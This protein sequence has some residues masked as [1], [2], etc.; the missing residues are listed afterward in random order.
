MHL[1]WVPEQTVQIFLSQR[2]FLHRH[3]HVCLRN[4]DRCMLQVRFFLNAS[5][6]DDEPIHVATAAPFVVGV[7]EDGSGAPKPWTFEAGAVEIT[8]DI[9]PADEEVE[10][11]TIKECGVALDE[12]AVQV[13]IVSSN[14][15]LCQPRTEDGFLTLP[16][17]A[18]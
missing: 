18:H 7:A 16:S 17:G 3:I 8:A 5:S 9:M 11:Q 4:H 14:M 15:S 1:T 13:C 2:E 12:A 6:S 10:K